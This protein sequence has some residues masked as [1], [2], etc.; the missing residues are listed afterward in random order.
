MD[1]EPSRRIFSASEVGN[2]VVCPEAWRLKYLV[3]SSFRK[4]GADDVGQQLRKRWVEN[5]ELSAQLRYYTKVVFCLLLML[6]IVVFIADHRKA[7]RNRAAPAGDSAASITA[8]DRTQ[9]PKERER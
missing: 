1:K 4:P 6:V 2:Y 9:G 7:L 5:Q 3:R 8:P